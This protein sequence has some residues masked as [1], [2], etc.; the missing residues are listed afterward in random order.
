MGQ[1]IRKINNG[2]YTLI[3]NEKNTH[4]TVKISTVQKGAL[5]GK[6]ILSLL[7]GSDN[8]HSYKGFAFVNDND[9][10]AVWAKH[11]T[12]KFAQIAHILFS[13][14]VLDKE[15]PFT[16]RVTMKVSKRCMRCNRKLTTPE[17]IELGIGPEC[18]KMGF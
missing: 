17:S 8:E 11:R 15:S 10:I 16:N 4:A 9:M 5:K 7:I 6:R 2:T 18:R 12:S 1:S 13:L 3:N 14:C